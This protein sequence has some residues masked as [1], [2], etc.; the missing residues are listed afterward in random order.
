MSI[1]LVGSIPTWLEI[2]SST[3][4]IPPIETRYQHLPISEL[5]WEDFEKLCLR[6]VRTQSD[7]EYCNCYGERG[8]EQAGID[9]FARKRGTEKYEVYQCK[10]VKNFGPSSIISAVNKFLGGDWVDR[11]TTFILC[12]SNSLAEKKCAEEIERQNQI[13]IKKGITLIPWDISAISAL[14][15]NEPLIVDD[16]FGRE[17][18]RLFNGLEYSQLEKRLDSNAIIEFRQKLRAFYK[19]V[20][21][22]HDTVQLPASTLSG[23]SCIPLERR[24]I[25]PDIYEEGV[26]SR[27]RD[28]GNDSNFS[29]QVEYDDELRENVEFTGSFQQQV[30]KKRV[31]LDSWFISNSRKVILGGPGSGKSTL[32]R[33]IAMDLLSDA[34][35]IATIA[36]KWGQYL[37]VWV[38][39]ALWTKQL[40]NV[41]ECSLSELMYKWLKMWNE[42]KLWPIVE[43]ALNDNRLLLLVDG[44]DE[45]T[46]E[47][48]AQ[49]ALNLL[50]VFVEQRDIP[51]V[52]TSRPHGYQRLHMNDAN[53]SIGELADFNQTQQCKYAFIWFSHRIR[54]ASPDLREEIISTTATLEVNDFLVELNKSGDIRE[55]AKVPLLL[56]L[57]IFHKVINVRLPQTRFKAYDSLINNLISVHPHKR[58]AA[59]LITE[60]MSIEETDLKKILSYLACFAHEHYPEGLIDQEKAILAVE[61]FLKDANCGF[62]LSQNE[63]RKMSHKVI[64]TGEDTL[65]ILVMRSQTEI[66][67][68]YRVFQEY[69]AAHH[70]VHLPINE[71]TALIERR[72]V[73][74]QWKEVILA[75]FQLTRRSEEIKQYIDIIKKVR[76]SES[77]IN[78]AGLDLLVFEVA[79]GDYNCSSLISNELAEEAFR[80]IEFNPWMYQ[81]EQVLKLVLDG[82]RSHKVK[83]K[84]KIKLQSWFPRRL[85]YSSL[86]SS[87]LQWDDKKTAIENCL[88]GVLSEAFSHKRDAAAT[89]VEISK[90]DPGVFDQLSFYY[91]SSY[92]DITKAVSLIA[93][94]QGWPSRVEKSQYIKLAQ[95]SL[96]PNLRF[97]ALEANVELKI[98]NEKDLRELIG[99]A[100]DH[101]SLAYFWQ[102]DISSLFIK[103]WPG[104]KVVK[105]ICIKAVSSHRFHDE[106]TLKYDIAISVLLRG[107]PGD[108]DVV[109][110]C[111]DEL[112]IEDYPFNSLHLDAWELIS[113]N[114]KNSPKLIQAID[115]WIINQKFDELNISLAALTG[116]TSVGKQRL[117][118]MLVT[119]K[120]PHWPANSLL[121]GW[122]LSDPEVNSALTEMSLGDTKTSSRIAHLMPQIIID[123]KQCRKRLL[124]LLLDDDCERPDFVLTGLI[125]LGDIG[126]NDNILD[127]VLAKFANPQGRHRLKELLFEKIIVNFTKD[128]RVQELAKDSLNKHD[129]LHFKALANS[130][131]R[132]PEFKEKI[133]QLC[134]P[135]PEHLRKVIAEFYGNECAD[136]DF[137]L[138]QLKLYD[139]E[140]SAEVKTQASIGYHKLL[141]KIGSDCQA[142]IGVLSQSVVCYGHDYEA[143]R[144]AAFCGLV[145]IDRLDVMLDAKETNLAECTIP[146][147]AGF[148]QNLVFSRFIVENWESLTQR[149]GENLE[150]R[151]CMF[152][153]PKEFWGAIAMFADESAIVTQKL[154]E[155]M[156]ANEEKLNLRMLQFLDR[157]KPKSQF[158]LKCLLSAVFETQ[159]R[160]ST[161]EQ[162]AL[163]DLIGL[164]FAKNKEVYD[165]LVS[166][167]PKEQLELC[168]AILSYGWPD[169]PEL[170]D[171]YKLVQ[172]GYKLNYTDY[173]NIISL[174]GE[175]EYICQEII[176]ACEQFPTERIL[177]S[178]KC[179]VRRIRSDEQLRKLLINALFT[180]EHASQKISIAKLLFRS[181]GISE[182][183]QCWCNNE[184]NENGEGF[185]DV[186]NDITQRNLESTQIVALN[187]LIGAIG[188]Q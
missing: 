80:E 99:L 127:I 148:S 118:E 160:F 89:L 176:K 140:V 63:A 44:L 177:H 137:A 113:K 93:L 70:A 79:F 145:V 130:Y 31:S 180:S 37:P 54:E 153:E 133:A 154:L 82:V 90:D 50:Q 7:V 139:C 108:E 128:S 143:R 29:K 168:I 105:D 172:S 175:S 186:G 23:S 34:P 13:L 68:F 100:S 147:S 110:Y 52:V 59:A 3:S 181:S 64:K 122:G 85:G 92:D 138:S 109:D 187:I 87:F 17:W 124:E 22:T 21:N 8:Q 151:L 49:V 162:R 32:L 106:K 167:M 25:L 11:T 86:F 188:T 144:Q 39:F 73:D 136:I 111:V 38:P 125:A 53:W 83:E 129:N 10:K 75:I 4:V 112:E 61:D 47:G 134:C 71:Q 78:Q 55:L 45:W 72:C 97:A 19:H 76:K 119:S 171:A 30:L 26:L 96:S 152:R 121:Q 182:E 150:R 67:F 46:D 165:I 116:R 157:V 126:D 159:K 35:T 74:T 169:S 178:D 27:G 15:K 120:F 88:K 158:M 57:L 141:K 36:Q 2:P 117:L 132:Y 62:G 142:E 183:L 156:S 12:T 123:Q 18:V 163:C 24:Y 28:Y 135:L 33:F 166:K 102:S 20:F 14:L 58:R 40:S 81:R 60:S 161:I 91:L 155:F 184:I 185:V 170:Q 146:I 131:A 173:F 56:H 95:R 69:L 42:E 84:V 103:G 9:L 179:L 164:Q 65:G 48:S 6:L 174:K 98:H 101:S 77:R 41:A 66:G 115:K 107:Y 114:F 51:V 5:E 1:E 43:K 94:T 149:L 104:S 16:F